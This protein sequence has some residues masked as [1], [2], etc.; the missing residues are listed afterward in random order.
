VADVSVQAAGG[1]RKR[2][3]EIFVEKRIL[4]P[5]LV[6]RGLALGRRLQ[7]RFGTLMEDLGFVS[8]EEL[9]QALALQY[10]LQFAREFAKFSF[11]QELLQLVPFQTAVEHS[12]F[13]LKVAGDT[14]ALAMVD[15]T[16]DMVVKSVEESSKLRVVRVLATRLEMSRAVC[17]HYL[18]RE[19]AAAHT[20]N[21]I[22]IVDDDKLIRT[23]LSV[24]LSNK[25]YRVTT[26][27]NGVVAYNEIVAMRPD[28]VITDKEMPKRDGY[29][30]LELLK[31]IPDMKDT[32]VLLIT[33]SSSPEDEATAYDKGFFD[34]ISKPFFSIVVEAKV[35][36]ALKSKSASS[37]L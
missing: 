32:P 29:Q 17:R 3:G 28:V 19:F 1:E 33:S 16:L 26:A 37:S 22:L 5:L 35:R 10:G 30:L 2:L 9:A 31:R 12:V 8:G 34:F 25:G 15:P 6:E 13:P 23:S 18:G 14:L 20:G 27:E 24:M 36:R 4:T 7:K 11:P 21:S